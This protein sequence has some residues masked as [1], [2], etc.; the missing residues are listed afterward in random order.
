[1]SPCQRMFPTRRIQRLRRRGHG[2]AGIRQ[3]GVHS[4]AN[5][6]KVIS[7]VNGKSFAL[8]L[9]ADKEHEHTFVASLDGEDLPVEIIEVK[10]TSATLRIGSWIGFFEYRRSH[11]KLREVIHANRTFDVEIK[12]PQQDELERLLA[13]YR[14]EGAGPSTEKQ[15]VAPMPGRILEIYVEPGDDVE[16]GQVVGVLEAMKME[17]EIGSTVEGTVK[18]VLVK[19]GDTVALKDALIQFE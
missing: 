6:M 8:D 2:S 18:E 4:G 7:F 10:P 13:K 15:V 11:G 14:K 19:A 5:L 16:L 12:T 17:N 1:M 3:G 9:V